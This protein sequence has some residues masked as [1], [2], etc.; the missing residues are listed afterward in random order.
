MVKLTCLKVKITSW[1]TLFWKCNKLN[2]IS[3]NLNKYGQNK[4]ECCIAY[5]KH[6]LFLIHFGFSLTSTR[7]LCCAPNP[8]H[9]GWIEFLGI[10]PRMQIKTVFYF[11]DCWSCSIHWFCETRH[12]CCQLL[13]LGH[14]CFCK[15][16]VL[17]DM[18]QSSLTKF[19][20]LGEWANANKLWVSPCQCQWRCGFV[21][22]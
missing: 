22:L 20:E 1:Q 12:V 14:K 6:G 4:H 18:S 15:P 9:P 16:C 5:C 7:L 10:F 2:R 11:L 17:A 21:D 3:T 13:W 19:D 8:C